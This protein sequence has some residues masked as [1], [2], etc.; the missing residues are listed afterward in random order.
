[1]GELYHRSDNGT[2]TLAASETSALTVKTAGTSDDLT[3]FIDD[4]TGG[5]PP[6]HSLIAEVY[7]SLI[8]EWLVY[9]ETGASTARSHDYQAV[10]EKMRVTLVNETTASATVRMVAHSYQ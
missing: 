6:S 3:V 7:D 1:M 8:D 4:G 10:G 2:E 9:N 5:T